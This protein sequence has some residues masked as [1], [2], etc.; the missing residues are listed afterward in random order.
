MDLRRRQVLK[1]EI[2]VNE[3]GIEDLKEE[4]RQL[5]QSVKDFDSA[6][7]ITVDKAVA[8]MLEID[9]QVRSLESQ[10]RK[11]KILLKGN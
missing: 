10:T 4:R 1:Y 9:K 2:Q 3:K 6:D 5:Y 11:R 8:R 7:A